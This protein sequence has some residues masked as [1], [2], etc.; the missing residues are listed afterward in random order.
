MKFSLLIVL[1]ASVMLASGCATAQN[2]NSKWDYTVISATDTHKEQ[3]LNQLASEGWQ[4]VET[5][6]YKG[7][8]FKR[9]KY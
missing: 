4:L 6:P 7:L 2:D 8:L 5:D 9:A 3:K 1:C